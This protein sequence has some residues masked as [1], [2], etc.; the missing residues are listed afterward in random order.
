M[1]VQG[2]YGKSLPSAQFCYEAKTPLKYI[3]LIKIIFN[4]QSHK[5]RRRKRRRKEEKEERGKKDEKIKTTISP[6]T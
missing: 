5:Q 3:L 6:Y 1:R 4:K 2:M